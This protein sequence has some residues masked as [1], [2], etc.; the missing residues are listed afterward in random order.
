MRAA[1][2]SKIPLISAVG[3]ETDTTLIDFASDI[4]APTPTAAAELAVPVRSDLLAILGA[5][6]ERRRRAVTQGIAVRRQRLNDLSRALPSPGDLVAFQ[7]QGL[8]MLAARLPRALMGLVTQRQSGLV[9]AGAG[10][11]P[12]ILRQ[13]VNQKSRDVTALSNQ[14]RTAAKSVIERQR[15]RLD[16]LDRLLETLG[17]KATLKRGYAVIRDGTGQVLSN[18]K[19]AAAASG[20]AIEFNDGILSLGDGGTRKS[21][22]R[23][24]SEDSQGNLF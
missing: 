4:R 21:T 6:E 3:H 12:A 16:G 14:F 8:D 17:Y 2:A 5:L 23:P 10:L 20:L 7:A 11:R 13:S 18:K 19:A 9:A 22:T 15:T 24:K 1:A